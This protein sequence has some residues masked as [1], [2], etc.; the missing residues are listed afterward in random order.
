[1]IAPWA[2]CEDEIW[3]GDLAYINNPHVLAPYKRSRAAAGEEAP[4]LSEE[5]KLFNSLHSHRRA[6]IERFLSYLCRHKFLR[7]NSHRPKFI[8][9]GTHLLWIAEVVQHR[10]SRSGFRYPTVMLR[11]AAVNFTRCACDLAKVTNSAERVAMKEMRDLIAAQLIAEEVAVRVEIKPRGPRN[12][13]VVDESGD[14][15]ENEEA[16][17]N[18]GEE[19]EEEEAE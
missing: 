11:D 4:Q 17:D 19:D 6:R 5:K 15:E 9:L 3:L 8:A 1:M 13:R 2:H 10:H 18:E 14:E 7:M 12:D 16:D